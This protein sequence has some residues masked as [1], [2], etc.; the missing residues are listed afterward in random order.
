MLKVPMDASHRSG[1]SLS[2]ILSENVSGTPCK[3]NEIRDK[4][5]LRDELRLPVCLHTSLVYSVKIAR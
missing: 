3:G 4:S 2:T 1:A 5:L